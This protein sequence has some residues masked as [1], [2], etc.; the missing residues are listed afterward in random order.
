MH[1]AGGSNIRID[2]MVSVLDEAGRI[3]EQNFKNSEINIPWNLV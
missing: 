2:K 1:L 3:L